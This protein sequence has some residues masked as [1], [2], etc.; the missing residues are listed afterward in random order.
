MRSARPALMCALAALLFGAATPAT[1]L[2]VKS[3]DP[4]LL[5]GLLYLGAALSVAP[6]AIRDRHLMRRVSKRSAIRL[7]GVV[8]LGGCVAPVMLMYGLGRAPAAS[9]SLWLNLETVWTALIAW[10]LFEEHLGRAAVVAMILVVAAGIGLA[11]P[12]HVEGGLAALLVAGACLG[13]SIDNNL[14][15]TIDELTPAQ[16]TFAKG[17]F[18]G[19]INLGVGLAHSNGAQGSSVLAAL[20]IGALGYGASL[21]LYIG[22]SQ[23]LGAARSQM[24]FASAPFAGTILAW[25]VLRE[26]LLPSQT[27]AA[28]IMIVAISMLLFARH[29][30]AHRHEST[31]HLH[32]HRHDDGHH[33]HVHAGLPPSA[34]HTH[35]HGHTTVTHTHPHLPDLHHRHSH[36]H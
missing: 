20:G 17:L 22:S 34:E 2:L 14:T 28:S 1:K 33:D 15:A 25:G 5:A 6:W 30:H 27:F 36:E 7:G 11:T 29:G 9:V 32:S 18:A 10:W 26:P 23:Q 8:I 35:M 12:V 3:L 4:L 21:V 24:L 13:W 16:I 31:E 19:I